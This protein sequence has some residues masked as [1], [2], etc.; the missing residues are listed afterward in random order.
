MQPHLQD[1]F[2]GTDTKY[3]KAQ[4]TDRKKRTAVGV[5]ANSG[6]SGYTVAPGSSPNNNTIIFGTE[7][8]NFPVQW[9]PRYTYAAGFGAN[10]DRYV[11][12]CVYHSCD[13]FLDAYF[14]SSIQL[15]ARIMRSLRRDPVYLLS[16]LPTVSLRTPMISPMDSAFVSALNSLL[17]Q[18]CII[19]RIIP[20]S[21][22]HFC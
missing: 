10:P 7:G 17:S 11:P 5:Y 19:D 8:P 9:N 12:S 20:P 22:H 6:L 13:A 16:H 14:L 2:G 3:L 15:V 21:R 1:V 18:G 4:T